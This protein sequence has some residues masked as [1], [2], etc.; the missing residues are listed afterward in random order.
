[1]HPDFLFGFFLID[2]SFPVYRLTSFQS[3]GALKQQWWSS[4]SA[5]WRLDTFAFCRWLFI[6]IF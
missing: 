4:D 1:V 2:S 3:C 5:D 6:Q